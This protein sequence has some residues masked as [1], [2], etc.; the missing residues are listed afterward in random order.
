MTELKQLF[1]EQ[2]GLLRQQNELL[3]QRNRIATQQA[4]TKKWV[5]GSWPYCYHGRIVG[6]LF[7]CAGDR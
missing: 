5:C 2:N 6:A 1:E 4:R 3:A 7:G